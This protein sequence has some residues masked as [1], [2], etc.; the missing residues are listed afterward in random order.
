MS[1][2]APTTEDIAAALLAAL[3]PLLHAPDAATVTRVVAAVRAAN[4]PPDVLAASLYAFSKLVE[5]GTPPLKFFREAVGALVTGGVLSR[6]V[7]YETIDVETHTLLESIPGLAVEEKRCRTRLWFT[8]TRFNLFREESE[9]YA[10]L[11]SLMWETISAPD[12]VEPDATA[13]ALLALIGQFNLDTIRVIELVL[14]AAVDVVNERIAKSGPLPSDHR[15]PALFVRLLEEFA[16]DHVSSVIGAM[17]Q[18][19][20]AVPAVA[21]AA[22]KNPSPAASKKGAAPTN[23]AASKNPKPSQPANAPAPSAPAEPEV[24]TPAGF[25]SLIAVLIRE[26]RMTVADVW[27][28]LSPRDDR[29][30]VTKFLEYEEN[31]EELSKRVSLPSVNR[32][33][34]AQDPTMFTPTRIGASERDIFSQYK[35]VT[36]GP[37]AQ[38]SCQ[39]LDFIFLLIN[40][41]RWDDAMDAILSLGIDEEHV[42]IA[43]H[44]AIGVALTGFVEALI[45]PSL[46]SRFPRLYKDATHLTN[47]IANLGGRANRCPCPIRST[48]QLLSS[49]KDSPGA[50]VRQ[51]LYVLGPHARTSPGLLH[52][53]CRLLKGRS[54]PEA[55]AIMRDVILPA[56]SLL[57]SNI[58]LGDAIWDVLRAWPHTKRWYIYGHLQ[59]I[60]STSCAAYQVVAARAS[61]EMKYVLKRLT[62]ETHKQHAITITKITH[63]QAL[64]VFSAA[65]DRI[66]GYPPDAVT[67]SPVVEACRDCSELAV[68]MLLYLIVDRMAD[69]KRSRLK[70]DGINIAQ[71][72]ATL[73][74]FLGLSL[75][76]LPVNSQQIE[77]VLSFLY[78]KLVLDREALLITALSDII[79]CV[80]DI[81]TESNLTA[82]QISAQGGGRQLRAVVTGVWGRLQPDVKMVGLASDYKQERE[83]RGAMLAL[84]GAFERTQIHVYLAIAIAQLTRES[85]YQEDLRTMPLKLGANIVD[86]ARASLQQLSQF[87]D[88]TP[89]NMTRDKDVRAGLWNPL[90][91]IGLANM[92]VEMGVSTSSAVVVMSP[93]LDYHV[94]SESIETKDKAGS[95]ESAKNATGGVATPQSR[96]KDGDIKMGVAKSENDTESRND[97]SSTVAFA[98]HISE[99]TGGVL[100]PEL[101]RAFWTLKPDDIAI[102]LQMYEDEGKRLSSMKSVWEKEV[103]RLRRS[104]H[105]DSDRRRAETELRKIREFLEALETEKSFLI[106]KNKLVLDAL[107]ERKSLICS[108][109]VSVTGADTDR[110]VS[111]LL[112][113]CIF[114]RCRVAISEAIFCSRFILLLLQLDIPVLNYARYFQGLLKLIPIVLS[115]CSENEAFSIARL[116]KEV[117]TTLEKW[118]SNR[119]VFDS[120]ASSGKKNG[121]RDAIEPNARPM[122]HEHY[123]QWL[124]DIHEALTEGLCVILMSGEYLYSRNSLSVLAGIADVFPK[125]SEHS[126]AI[127]ACVQKLSGSDLPDIRLSSSGVL[128]RLKSGKAKRLPEHIFKLRPSSGGGAN[129]AGGGRVRKEKRPRQ[130]EPSKPAELAKGTRVAN[131]APVLNAKLEPRA[132]VGATGTNGNINSKVAKATED[133]S[134]DK[135]NLN[136]NAEEFVPG[137]K[138]EPMTR[139]TSATAASQ[140]RPHP[141]QENPVKRQRE[142]KSEPARHG[143]RDDIKGEDFGER[144]K[145]AGDAPLKKSRSAD[146]GLSD[147]NARQAGSTGAGAAVSEARDNHVPGGSGQSSVGK[148]GPPEKPGTGMSKPSSMGRDL[149]SRDDGRKAPPREPAG[150]GGPSRV[151]IRGSGPR[152]SPPQEQANRNGSARDGHR[153]MPPRDGPAQGSPKRASSGREVGRA[154]TVRDRVGRDVGAHSRGVAGRES[155]SRMAA[156]RNGA[157]RESPVRNSQRGPHARE[158][159]S[160]ETNGGSG[161]DMGRR[162]RSSD[163]PQSSYQYGMPSDPS[164]P[165]HDAVEYDESFA[166]GHGVKRR[167]EQGARNLTSFDGDTR[168]STRQRVEDGSYRERPDRPGSRGDGGGGPERRYAPASPGRDASRFDSG[169][170]GAAAK[171]GWSEPGRG[172]GVHDGGHERGGPGG[173]GG[174][175]RR[176]H[177]GQGSPGA[178]KGRGGERAGDFDGRDRPGSRARDDAR[179]DGDFGYDERGGSRGGYREPRR[180]AG[181]EDGRRDRN[182]RRNNHGRS[183]GGARRRT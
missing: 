120:E 39:K 160:R 63:G 180:A 18:S 110:F 78:T 8:Q 41:C 115:S 94:D 154:A 19:Y 9:G 138:A 82:T 34:N 50:V 176:D 24:K 56:F 80:A 88:T 130:P 125:V 121:F 77:G 152:A 68:D 79:K 32:A 157:R 17:L 3:D 31:M 150:R 4:P 151:Q 48:D 27:N 66:Q 141:V 148:G 21:T 163:P 7:L 36:T 131:V 91:R 20:H 92:V 40:M 13:D 71:W 33:A 112:Q 83:K 139:A 145:G 165:N 44:P 67:I 129:A 105:G 72:Y 159:P 87:M 143:P 161:K 111:C 153:G 135:Q 35:F 29:E 158:A 38:F 169:F 26:G 102:P 23:G 113:E 6:S 96:D 144:S 61:Y 133:A 10:K 168:G 128:A 174:A 142:V 155:Q 126:T 101:V 57:Q 127:E 51:M 22:K 5:E 114:S 103:E 76:K 167:R 47:A 49:E 55:V 90:K 14:S 181:R 123:C 175:R 134:K 12:D 69:S 64:P 60:V 53:L 62:S 132:V 140:G 89:S 108:S 95:Q 171:S 99:K 74:L 182:F 46:C 30:L 179:G 106:K 45:N 109:R 177:E 124:F 43:A 137:V 100:S 116:V 97:P 170:G 117:L 25:L 149:P 173:G 16:R 59:N 136:P 166:D 65:I 75:R 85:V 15:L 93:V 164:M 81:E 107:K 1:P 172:R 104:G 122:K 73:S 98:A 118:R 84:V 156:S 58:G 147:A 119:K 28:N 42:D 11:I 162:R 146:R 52:A 70:D 178:W 54:E 2:A 183:G 37:F 86:R